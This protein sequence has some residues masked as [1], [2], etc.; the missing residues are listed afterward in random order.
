[1]F[2]TSSA[3][4]L[5]TFPSRG[6]LGFTHNFK[7]S[8]VGDGFPVPKK[9]RKSTGA[10][11]A[12]LRTQRQ[13]VQNQRILCKFNGVSQA[14]ALRTTIE[15]RR[16]KSS[17]ADPYLLLITYYLL[18][19]GIHPHKLEFVILFLMSFVGRWLT[20]AVRTIQKKTAEKSTV[21][22]SISVKNNYSAFSCFYGKLRS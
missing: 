17:V 18:L 8:V 10:E 3:S 6:R 1:M 19:I 13:I 12:P 5:G 11:T 7:I 22:K 2:Y 20:A 16:L 15:D 14:T 9:Q 21:F 4:F